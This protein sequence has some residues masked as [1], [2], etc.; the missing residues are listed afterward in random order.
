MKL[1]E[2]IVGRSQQTSPAYSNSHCKLCHWLNACLRQLTAAND[3]TLIPV[4]GRPKR[5]AVMDEIA[6]IEDLAK[7]NLEIARATIQ[8][9]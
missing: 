6:S 9:Y 8:G 7:I 5:Y 1:A 2:K 3:L 4:L